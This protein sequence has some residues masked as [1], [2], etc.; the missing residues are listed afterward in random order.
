MR[1][2]G[3]ARCPAFLLSFLPSPVPSF[4][5]PTQVYTE[6]RNF[7]GEVNSDQEQ[8]VRCGEERERAS[9]RAGERGQVCGVEDRCGWSVESGVFMK[10]YELG[11]WGRVVTGCHG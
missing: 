4:P 7:N 11:S 3:A 1:E 8:G 10:V 5:R 2:G 6:G 9:E